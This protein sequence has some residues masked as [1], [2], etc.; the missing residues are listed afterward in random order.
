M[1]YKLAATIL[2]LFFLTPIFSQNSISGVV[3]DEKKEPLPFVNILI[4]QNKT[5]GVSSDIDGNFSIQSQEPIQT[6]TLSFVGFKTLV[7]VQITGCPTL[8]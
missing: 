6:I 2:F 1:Y 5:D 4:N 7:E 3:L 8:N